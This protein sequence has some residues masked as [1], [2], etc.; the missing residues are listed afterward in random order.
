[1]TFMGRQRRIDLA[2]RRLGCCCMGFC[3]NLSRCQAPIY[4]SAFLCRLSHSAL[5]ATARVV[6]T[7]IVSKK[8]PCNTAR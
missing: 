3:S 4:L 2:I 8:A 6:H 1:M 7:K 5:R